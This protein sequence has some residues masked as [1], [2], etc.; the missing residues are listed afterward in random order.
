[1][2]PCSGRYA[3]GMRQP[4]VWRSR[5]GC[6][7]LS[8][9]RSRPCKAIGGTAMI[10]VATLAWAISLST[11]LYVMPRIILEAIGDLRDDRRH[12]GGERGRRSD[13]R[14]WHCCWSPRRLGRCWADSPPNSTVLVGSWIRDATATS[15]TTRAPG[16]ARVGRSAAIGNQLMTSA[17]VR[18]VRARSS[19]FSRRGYP[20]RLRPVLAHVPP[21]AMAIRNDDLSRGLPRKPISPRPSYRPERGSIVHVDEY[22]Q[23]QWLHGD[24]QHHAAARRAHVAGRRDQRVHGGPQRQLRRRLDPGS[25]RPAAPA[26]SHLRRHRQPNRSLEHRPASSTSSCMPLQSLQWMKVLGPAG[27]GTYLFSRQAA[28]PRKRSLARPARARSM[29]C[30]RVIAR[31]P[32]QPTVIIK[33]TSTGQPI[34]ERSISS[35]TRPDFP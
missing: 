5:D 33:G 11:M 4:P 3:P 18:R 35:P 22:G 16:A 26:R 23:H 20:G 15:P 28:R 19:P 32:N 8:G 9:L 2:Q 29:G 24:H 17:S 13:L 7:Y 12:L 30:C 21:Q 34:I 27:L 10:T 25:C 1:M 6:P 31:V 14:L